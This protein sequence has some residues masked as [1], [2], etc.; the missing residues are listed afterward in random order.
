MDFTSTAAK[1]TE[2]GIPAP[3]RAAGRAASLWR[4]YAGI[5]VAV[6]VVGAL[7]FAH[8]LALHQGPR[9]SSP[10]LL[11]D[12]VFGLL[13]APALLWYAY[14]LGRKVGRPLLGLSRDRLAEHLSALAFG[15]GLLST[16]ILLAGF[17]RLYDAPLFLAVWLAA[18]VWLRPELTNAATGARRAAADWARRGMPSAPTKGQRAVLLILLLTLGVTVLRVMVPL[19]SYLF[20]WDGLAYHLAG[21]KIYLDHHS[22]IPLPDMPLANAPS[23]EEMLFIPALMT[24]IETIGGALDLCFALLLALAVFTL[25]RRHFGPRPAWLALLAICSTYWLNVIVS[26]SLTDFASTFPLLLAVADVM[27]WAS[28]GPTRS[29]STA[30]DGAPAMAPRYR[31]LVRAGLLAGLGV[32]YK[33]TSIPVLPAL[34]LVVGLLGLAVPGLSLPGRVL[35]AARSCILVGLPA[36][37]VLAPWLLKNIY[38][39]RHPFYPVAIATTSSTTDGF[40]TTAASSPAWWSHAWWLVS[41]LEGLIRNF[42]GAGCIVLLACPLLL[43]KRAGVTAILFTAIGGVMW[44][45]FVVDASARYYLLVIVM[46]VVLAAASFYELERRCRVSPFLFEVVAVAYLLANSVWVLGTGLEMLGRNQALKAAIGGVSAY[47]YVA[48]IVRPYQA[49]Q[50]V[51]EHT[52]PDAIVAMVGD[53]RGFYLNRSYLGEWYGWRLARLELS[54]AS[55][56]AE[57]A[58]WC[59]GGVRYAVFNRGSDIT[60]SLAEAGI[61]AADSFAWIRQPGLQPRVLFSANGVDVLAVQPCQASGRP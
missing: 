31:L 23:G 26:Q 11:A 57:L 15:I 32:S 38:F 35:R 46:A 61:R 58:L 55:R 33:L 17:L 29:P 42:G 10:L 2:G 43:W 24:G 18:T 51:D 4:R 22:F 59:R 6:A 21:P 25:A 39:F 12:H 41:T 20:N 54:P 8:E 36:A 1:A 60:D 13:F 16:A 47:Q 3:S 44:L 56:R 27:A 5:A 7:A 30:S 34:V 28:P 49:E 45:T 50:Y 52:P 9:W 19:D 14:A 40:A 53:T 48:P 37:L